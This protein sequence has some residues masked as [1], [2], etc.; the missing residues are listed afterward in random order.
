MKLSD[1]GIQVYARQLGV[2]PATA[3][4]AG[5]SRVST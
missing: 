5:S 1:P 4:T 2:S 3:L